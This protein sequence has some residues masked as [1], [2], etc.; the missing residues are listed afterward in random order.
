MRGLLLAVAAAGLAATVLTRAQGPEARKPLDVIY[1]P[2]PPE[3]VTEMLKLAEVAPGDV[4]YDL[5]SG[6]GRIVIEA[7]RDFGAARGVGIDLDPIRTGE[8]RA[9]ARAAGVEDRVTFLTQDLF[10][11][12][13]REASVVAVY[14]LPDLLRR[15]EP[16]FRALA[17]VHTTTTWGPHG[18]PIARFRNWTA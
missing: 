1:V 10:E 14:L 6:D 8:A 9:N 13:F 5:G 16:A 18:R 15:L 3:V 7:V 4:V 11:S 12:D 2:T 17:P